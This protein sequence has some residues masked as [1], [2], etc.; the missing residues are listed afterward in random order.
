MSELANSICKKFDFP[1]LVFWASVIYA[2]HKPLSQK[3]ET[4][5]LDF[6]GLIESFYNWK[7][8]LYT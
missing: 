7:I 6:F 8:T 2:G 5:V 3:G 1:I 4:I